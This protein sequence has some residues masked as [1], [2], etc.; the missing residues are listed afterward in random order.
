MALTYNEHN[1]TLSFKLS[2]KE[3]CLNEQFKM[4]EIRMWLSV[5]KKTSACS[6]T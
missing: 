5:G 1:T 2:I 4:N 6:L 3:I